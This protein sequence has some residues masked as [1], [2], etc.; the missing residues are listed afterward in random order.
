M[1][2]HV[3]TMKDMKR[4]EV[5][6]FRVSAE[7]KVEITSAAKR[8]GMDT[9]DFIRRAALEPEEVWSQRVDENPVP[10]ET[11]Q[12]RE[13]KAK[14]RQAVAAGESYEV[15]I[16]PSSG[17]KVDDRLAKLTKQLEAQG[18]PNAEE[19]ARKRLGL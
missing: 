10:F 3:S 14:V 1:T 6:Q 19:A 2:C 16:E 4:N 8:A 15:K 5:I 12:D 13:N 7:E 9:S 17:A 18:K 11:S